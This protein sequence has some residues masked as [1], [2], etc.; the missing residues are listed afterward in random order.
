[1]TLTEPVDRTRASS[2]PVLEV[3]DLTVTFPTPDGDVRAVRGVDCN[4]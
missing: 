3:H 2:A 1:M 4:Q